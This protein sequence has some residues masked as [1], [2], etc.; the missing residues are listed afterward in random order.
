MVILRNILENMT[1][2]NQLLS[3]EAGPYIKD[4]SL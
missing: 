1:S 3:S 2:A 4:T